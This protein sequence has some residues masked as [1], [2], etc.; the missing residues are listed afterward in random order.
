[1]LIKAVFF[2]LYNDPGF[3]DVFMEKVL[4]FN[5]LG[6]MTILDADLTGLAAPIVCDGAHN[7]QASRY[8]AKKLENIGSK[9]FIMFS[10]F[11]IRTLLQFLNQL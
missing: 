7:A 10:L 8:L 9:K 1:M 2:D 4:S 11:M 5:L 6:R 3:L